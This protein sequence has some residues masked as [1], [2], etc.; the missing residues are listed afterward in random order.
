[1]LKRILRDCAMVFLGLF[2]AG[3]NET[4]QQ[5][6]DYEY[7]TK[8]P[9]CLI[10]YD[11][12][13][14]IWER[15]KKGE[16]FQPLP[17]GNVLLIPL[18]RNYRFNGGTDAFAIAHP[19]LYT[20]CEDIE[21]RLVAF[22]QRDNLA[23]LIIWAHGFFPTGVPHLASLSPKID[24]RTTDLLEL[25]RCI[26][27]EDSKLAVAMKTLLLDA[28]FT[29]EKM[30]VC[31]VGP[32]RSSPST[33]DDSPYNIPRLVRTQKY[34]GRWVKYEA[35]PGYVL[36]GFTPGTRVVNRLSNKDKKMVAE[37]AEKLMK[38]PEGKED[39]DKNTD[40]KRTGVRD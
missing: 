22:G 14:T 7:P 26:D 27:D 34:E 31:K 35:I 3:C 28:D 40:E 30:S 37:F 11:P 21:N 36:W 5:P 8:D 2:C 13:R 6:D 23:R 25:Q 10:E 18:Y 4:A 39:A 15:A 32:L 1:M 16:R 9:L 17:V 29:I 20:Q 38:K 33:H 24:G 12:A 19:F